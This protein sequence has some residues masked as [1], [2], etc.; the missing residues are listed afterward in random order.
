MSPHVRRPSAVRRVLGSVYHSALNLPDRML[1]RR[2]H[3]V[4][5]QRLA[6]GK[7]PREILVVCY[8]NVCRSPYMQ[9]VLKRALPDVAVRSAGFFGSD[10]EVPAISMSL[11]A[12]RGI[13][14][15][16]FRSR[17]ITQSMING[18]DL[19]IV[20]D[21]NQERQIRR[22]FPSNRAQ[23]VVAGDLDPDFDSSR[24]IADPLN[25]PSEVFESS[26]NRLDRCA[27]TLVKLLPGPT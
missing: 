13:D 21:A 19:V 15:T 11:S 27:S 10:R 14:L 17:P 18:A 26:F 23:V 25:R 3:R 5:G 7:R 8:G 9:A 22:F 4:V 16:N 1:H 24:A 20:M 6:S 12:R 2:R